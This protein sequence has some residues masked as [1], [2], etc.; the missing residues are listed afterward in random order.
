MIFVFYSAR[1]VN[2]QNFLVNQDMDIRFKKTMS[3]KVLV[4]YDC[5]HCNSPLKSD[6]KDIGFEDTCP[7]C[8]R[9][10]LVPGKKEYERLLELQKVKAEK[11]RLSREKVEQSYEIKNNTNSNQKVAESK[12]DSDS[13]IK[14]TSI[15]INQNIYSST[16]SNQKNTG[17]FIPDHIAPGM[18]TEHN[19]PLIKINEL[20][21]RA[22]AQISAGEI[23]H[24]ILYGSNESK[25]L[26]PS[27]DMVNK[28]IP[29]ETRK[30]QN[31]FMITSEKIVCETQIH[32]VTENPQLKTT[33]DIN[34]FEFYSA[35]H[36]D[37]VSIKAEVI[38]AHKSVAGCNQSSKKSTSHCI[39]VNLTNGSF[40]SFIKT[41]EEALEVQKI[42][43]L[44][45]KQYLLKQDK[46]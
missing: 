43:V 14:N 1:L 19:M 27:C 11:E 35:Y 36:A 2:H 31:W 32:V 7:K 12:L 45:R 30:T 16:Q 18:D 17:G 21:P 8:E 39:V 25:T 34:E 37:I 3:G 24:C 6:V 33:D 15:P 42:L 13:T 29:L 10:F 44:L 46:K 23:V 9:V 5:P 40:S 26:P 20:P 28:S 4:T 38:N 22:R 41:L